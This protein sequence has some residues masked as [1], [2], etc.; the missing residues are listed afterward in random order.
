MRPFA[1][2]IGALFLL[3]ACATTPVHEAKYEA[4][5]RTHARKVTFSGSPDENIPFLEC[6]R[7]KGAHEVEVVEVGK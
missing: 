3:T 5:C 7:I 6:M 1:L 2:I 4:T